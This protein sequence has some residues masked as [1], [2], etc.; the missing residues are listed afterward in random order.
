LEIYTGLWT[1]GYC[2]TLFIGAKEINKLMKK[3]TIIMGIV[4]IITFVLWPIIAL[5]ELTLWIKNKYDGD[6]EP[7]E[8]DIKVK[9]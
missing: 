8:E 4:L 1:L 9:W 5:A 3:N 2:L 6:E 7:D